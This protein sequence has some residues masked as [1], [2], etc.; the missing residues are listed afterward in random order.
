MEKEDYDGNQEVKDSLNNGSPTDIDSV[1]E[2]LA[3]AQ[4][5]ARKAE[6][7][8]KNIDVQ[9]E[10][11]LRK[12]GQYVNQAYIACQSEERED[13]KLQKEEDTVIFESDELDSNLAEALH[14]KRVAAQLKAQEFMDEWARRLSLRLHILMILKPLLDFCPN[15][16]DE[17]FAT[18]LE[19]PLSQTFVS[20]GSTPETTV[21]SEDLAHAHIIALQAQL[22]HQMQRMESAQQEIATLKAKVLS[23][24]EK[25]RSAEERLAQVMALLNEDQLAQLSCK[26]H[27][28]ELG[29]NIGID[30]TRTINRFM[31]WILSFFAVSL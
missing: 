1:L 15:L 11:L 23:A 10:V 19:F 21:S 6:G 12:L 20:I 7:E 28:L 16:S 25:A 2:S 18:D 24:E 22:N 8:M 17:L 4:T 5:R 30:Y 31:S 29:V 26:K 14:K 13:E 9:L 27:N 3:L